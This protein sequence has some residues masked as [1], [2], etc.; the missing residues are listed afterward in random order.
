MKIRQV[1]K[2]K[3]GNA[4]SMSPNQTLSDAITVMS[5]NRIGS[6][7]VID[8]DTL[9]SIV[10]ERDVLIAVAQHKNLATLT[11]ADVMAPSL[12]TC[13]IDASLDEAMGLMITNTT[14][15]RIRHLP[16]VENDKFQAMISIGDV[17][18]ALLTK[19]EFE[20]KLLKNYIQNWPDED[21]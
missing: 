11:I 6:I 10:T 13:D 8:N 4:Y 9:L 1:I 20:N 12:I 18:E 17:V 5:E 14:G 3:G 2:N 21:K 19:T 15:R 7:V 16:V